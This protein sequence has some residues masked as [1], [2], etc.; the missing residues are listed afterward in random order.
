MKAWLVAAVVVLTATAG[1]G[2]RGPARP[3][4]GAAKPLWIA[5][6]GLSPAGEQVLVEVGE[7]GAP[8]S[9][10][11]L[12]PTAPPAKPR[13]V[14]LV[15]LRSPSAREL[16]LQFGL[17]FPNE[18]AWRR[19]GRAIAYI[20]GALP[21]IGATTS[22]Y[23]LHTHDLVRD[24][25]QT[26]ALPGYRYAYAL[27]WSPDGARIAFR[28]SPMPKG[29]IKNRASSGR[30]PMVGSVT[31]L[32]S[33]PADLSAPPQEQYRYPDEW[34]WS[35]DGKHLLCTRS[36][37]ADPGYRPPRGSLA[38]IVPPPVPVG[39]VGR[40]FS[41]P[42]RSKIA[43]DYSVGPLG[44]VVIVD[45]SARELLR[46]RDLP[47]GSLQ[48]AWSPDSTKLLLVTRLIS[49]PADVLS[50]S[51]REAWSNRPAAVRLVDVARKTVAEVSS[52]LF[53]DGSGEVFW[54]NVNGTPQFLC[55]S[56][57]RRSLR[58]AESLSSPIRTFAHL[59][60]DGSLLL[61]PPSRTASAPHP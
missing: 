29:G 39:G 49:P 5:R 57:D 34:W 14:W 3:S 53:G 13:R 44:A 46:V 16:G 2:R 4:A 15:D 59:Q 32:F 51:D 17:D 12:P 19:D 27:A 25:E 35:P 42:D 20:T 21:P 40:R 7:A 31:A 30:Q 43:I 36:P 10:Q 37:L 38:Q 22:D 9:P 23:R 55:A 52:P 8:A 6:V 41:S 28:A 56:D 1:C 48:A 61:D 24:T 47:N 33:V 58:V 45:R 50:P 60:A 11:S 18:A 26:M 54:V